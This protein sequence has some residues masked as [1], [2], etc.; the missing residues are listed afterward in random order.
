MARLDTLTPYAERLIDDYVYDQL[1]EA[2]VTLRAAFDRVSG[3][4]ARQALDDRDLHRR[5]GRAASSLRNAVLALRG[6]PPKKRSRLP[7]L[8]AVGV[9]AAGAAVLSR[10]EIRDLFPRDIASEPLSTDCGSDGM[11]PRT[12]EAVA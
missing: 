6:E 3:R 8:I 5:L 7:G 9:V 10:R 12:M 4:S 11:Q 2:V 1:A